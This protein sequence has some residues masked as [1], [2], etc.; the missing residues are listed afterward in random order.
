M[1]DMKEIEGSLLGVIIKNPDTLE[2]ISS[3]VSTEMLR[4]PEHRVLYEALKD[5]DEIEIVSVKNYLHDRN[6]LQSAGGIKYIVECFESGFQVGSVDYYIRTIREQHQIRLMRLH[7]QKVVNIA[8]DPDLDTAGKLDAIETHYRQ[9]MGRPVTGSDSFDK[10][11]TLIE[12]TISGRRQSIPLPWD[13]LTDLSNCLLPGTVTLICGNPGASKSFM[14]LESLVYWLKNGISCVCYMLEENVQY[15]LLRATAQLSGLS[16]IT[17]PKWVKS[18]PDETRLAQSQHEDILRAIGSII[19]AQPGSQITLVQLAQ[20]VERHAKAEV[21][22]ICIDPVTLAA[23]ST[24]Q[25][26]LEDGDFLEK[27]KRSAV[28]YD[29][30]VVLV[31]HPTKG[32]LVPG[33]DTLAGGAAYT[34]FSQSALWLEK[35]EPKDSDVRGA[36]GTVSQEH[37]RTIHILK[38]RNGIGQGAKMACNFDADSLTLCEEGLIVPE[39]K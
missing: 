13:K 37:N 22:V 27:I 11:T 24:R 5:I 2:S 29:V 36:C 10:L 21:R 39:R 14:L 28:D 8:D 9:S 6:L 17:N 4:H 18:H 33:L 23:Y 3:Q 31:T 16:S 30:S 20:W 15:Y 7:A 12:D 32:S 38:S 26:W 25:T 34:R 1:I 19:T 35:H